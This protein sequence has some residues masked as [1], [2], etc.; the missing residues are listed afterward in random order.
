MH[1]LASEA[2]PPVSSRRA[3]PLP[4]FDLYGQSH[5]ALRAVVT[6][7][8]VRMGRTAATDDADVLARLDE[9]DVVFDA[10]ASHL[11]EEATF[12]HVA[13]E[14]KLPGAAIRLDIEHAEQARAMEELRALAMRIRREPSQRAVRFRVL[15]LRYAAFVGEALVHMSDEELRT[16]T[17]FDDLFTAEEQRALHDALCARKTW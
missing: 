14:R 11:A 3:H 15:Y 16:Q 9:L 13:L 6:E 17:L 5:R 12:L 4:S 2:S 7:L 1:M 8:L 10:I